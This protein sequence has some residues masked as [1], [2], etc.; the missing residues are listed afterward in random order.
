MTITFAQARKKILE[1][2]EKMNAIYMADVFDEWTVI[3]IEGS[4]A[5]IIDYSGPRID[6]FQNEFA[7]DIRLLRS[8]IVSGRYGVGDFEFSPN[9]D[10]KL[11]DAFMVIGNGFYLV[12]NNTKKSMQDI[13]SCELWRKAQ[14]PFVLLSEEFRK[15]PMI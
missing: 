14:A 12:C 11:Y 10:G 1:C 13:C 9:G 3:S 6:D 2:M 15:E 8:K 4:K 5:S 7:D